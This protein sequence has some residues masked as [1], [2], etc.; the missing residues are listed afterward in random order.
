MCSAVTGLWT[1]VVWL[2]WTLVSL[3]L[4]V[5]ILSLAAMAVAARTC[6]CVGCCE[7]CWAGS[8]LLVSSVS[9][10]VLLVGCW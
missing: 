10:I 7:I 2:S 4:C 1:V 9:C 6:V 8:T 5:A 3:T